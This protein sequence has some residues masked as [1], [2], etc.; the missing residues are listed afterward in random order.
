MQ[1]GMWWD[2]HPMASWGRAWAGSAMGQSTGWG[3]LSYPR[4]CTQC[5]LEGEI[6][7]GALWVE[8][9]GNV[10]PDLEPHNSV[11]RPDTP[12]RLPAVHSLAGV[13]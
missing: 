6:S 3:P 11:A 9:A 12:Q 2:M 10:H 13:E 4:L 8:V 7:W 5:V 1:G